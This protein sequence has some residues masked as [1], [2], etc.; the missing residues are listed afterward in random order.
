MVAGSCLRVGG[1][2]VCCRAVPD[3]SIEFSGVLLNSATDFRN[4]TME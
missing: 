3:G 2:L 1:S 4:G